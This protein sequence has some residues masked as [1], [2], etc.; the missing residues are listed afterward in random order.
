MKNHGD[1]RLPG[2]FTASCA[3]CSSPP[4]AL[5]SCLDA[6]SA[7]DAN[8]A[9]KDAAADC[10]AAVAAYDACV[11]RK[12]SRISSADISG[13]KLFRV[14]EAYRVEEEKSKTN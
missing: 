11:W 12:C 13:K 8:A 5:F 1:G 7:A 3:A 4:D 14:A 9:A 2:F 10:S 6:L